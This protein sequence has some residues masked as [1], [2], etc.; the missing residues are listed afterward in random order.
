MRRSAADIGGIKRWGRG[1]GFTYG[2]GL[3]KERPFLRVQII[4]V[5]EDVFCCTFA[6][7]FHFSCKAYQ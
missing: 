6:H 1:Q 5:R 3:W 7:C 2:K 4:F